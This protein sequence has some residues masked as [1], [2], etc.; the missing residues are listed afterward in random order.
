[1]LSL[2]DNEI[3]TRTGKGTPMGDL[4]RRYWM[5]IM[6]AEELPKPDCPRCA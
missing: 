6:L 2:E 4:L 1:M 5:P 3:L